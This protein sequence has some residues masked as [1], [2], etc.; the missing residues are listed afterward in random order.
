VRIMMGT[1]AAAGFAAALASAAAEAGTVN[2]EAVLLNGRVPEAAACW[3]PT[4]PTPSTRADLLRGEGAILCAA[5][6][7]VTTVGT[8]VTR[9]RIGAETLRRLPTAFD[10]AHPE[11]SPEL[12]V[13]A[14]PGIWECDLGEVA[15]APG[16]DPLYRACLVETGIDVSDPA[17]MEPFIVN[18]AACTLRS[19]IT[20]QVQKRFATAPIWRSQLTEVVSDVECLVDPEVPSPARFDDRAG[21]PVNVCGAGFTVRD[22]DLDAATKRKLASFSSNGSWRLLVR[23]KAGNFIRPFEPSLFP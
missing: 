22:R 5:E 6:A 4:K 7:S 11:N 2:A 9:L 19:P 13:E 14:E 15:S 21:E 23:R 10:A 17:A 1:I 3:D 16:S 8:N 12:C 20:F 18:E